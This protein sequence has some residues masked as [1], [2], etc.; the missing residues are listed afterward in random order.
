M[1]KTQLKA[2]SRLAAR[3]DHDIEMSQIKVRSTLDKL[4]SW[5]IRPSCRFNMTLLILSRILEAGNG[6]GHLDIPYGRSGSKSRPMQARR[7]KRHEF[8]SDRHGI[9][10]ALVNVVFEA[11]SVR[12]I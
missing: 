8:T 7:S 3:N 9:S 10:L 1:R 12:R 2:S 5:R 6:E 11:I 4:R